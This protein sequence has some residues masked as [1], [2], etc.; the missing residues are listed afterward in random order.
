MRGVPTLSSVQALMA[1]ETHDPEKVLLYTIISGDFHATSTAFLCMNDPLNAL[2][3]CQS[4]SAA[5]MQA[6]LLLCSHPHGLC[7]YHVWAHPGSGALIC[8]CTAC[9]RA[10]CLLTASCLMTLI[11]CLLH[12][13]DEHGCCRPGGTA[14]PTCSHR[15]DVATRSCYTVACVHNGEWS[16]GVDPQRLRKGKVACAADHTP[17]QETAPAACNPTTVQRRS[18]GGGLASVVWFIHIAV[19]FDRDAASLRRSG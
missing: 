7:G 12:C 18:H 8:I 15:C 2:W 16:A 6:T 17:R 4:D 9:F 19:C 1:A 3:R 5:A 11:V 14:L 13:T 10:K